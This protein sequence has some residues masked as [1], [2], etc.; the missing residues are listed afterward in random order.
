MI[1]YDTH[2]ALKP[3][4]IPFLITYIEAYSNAEVSRLILG[5]T[6]SV[7]GE[8][9]VASFTMEVNP[10]LAKRVLKTNRR[11]TNLELTS[12]VK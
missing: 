12:L 4:R 2:N 3:P 11:L 7:E 8:T 1:Q 5:S 10:R 6:E 9:P